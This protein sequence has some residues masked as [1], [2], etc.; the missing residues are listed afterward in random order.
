MSSLMLASSSTLWMRL[1]I[2]LYSSFNFTRIRV[3][4]RDSWISARG[5]K[6]G[7]SKPCACRSAVYSASFRSVFRPGMFLMWVGLANS[8]G[9]RP[10]NTCHTGFQ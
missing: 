10:A 2:R 4:S 6:L 1:W 5:T 7:F 3:R 9:N 8:R